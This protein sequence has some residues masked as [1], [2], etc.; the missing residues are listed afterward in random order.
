[1]SL[2]LSIDVRFIHNSVARMYAVSCVWSSHRE[3]TLHTCLKR[4]KSNFQVSHDNFHFTSSTLQKATYT[5]CVSVCEVRFITL[6]DG[7]HDER[8]RSG[9]ILILFGI[10]YNTWAV[11]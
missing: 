9:R 2:L 10:F 1:M 4:K 5:M 8:R 6:S 11:A 7:A 3:R